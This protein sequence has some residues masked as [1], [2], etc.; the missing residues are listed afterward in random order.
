MGFDT[1]LLVLAGVSMCTA[2]AVLCLPREQPPA[3]A[4]PS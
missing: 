3:Q 4:V 2:A 1:L